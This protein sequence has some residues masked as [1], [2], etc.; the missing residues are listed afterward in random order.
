MQS[1]KLYSNKLQAVII[2]I[3]SLFSSLG[4]FASMNYN[5]NFE[6]NSKSQI[7]SNIPNFKNKILKIGQINDLNINE[8]F[9]ISQ[10]NQSL[11]I[12][13]NDKIGITYLEEENS[14]SIIEFNYYINE[15]QLI[16]NFPFEGKIISA[17]EINNGTFQRITYYNNLILNDNYKYIV[18]I[19]RAD[20]SGQRVFS[21]K[22]K[23]KLMLFE[24][25][26]NSIGNLTKTGLIGLEISSPKIEDIVNNLIKTGVFQNINHNYLETTDN[27]NLKDVIN[28]H[29]ITHVNMIIKELSNS[30]LNRDQLESLAK[31]AFEKIN[32]IDDEDIIYKLKIGITSE[33]KKQVQVRINKALDE[34]IKQR[35]EEKKMEEIVHKR[36]LK[37]Q[38]LERIRIAKEIEK[39]RLEKERENKAYLNRLKEFENARKQ[40]IIDFER[41]YK[42]KQNKFEKSIFERN[43]AYEKSKIIKPNNFYN[44]NNSGNIRTK[45]LPPEIKRDEEVTKPEPPPEE[46]KGNTASKTVKGE[47]DT[48]E[49]PI[50]PDAKGPEPYDPPKPSEDEIFTAVEQQAEFPGGPRAFE[51]FL[52]ENLRY[53][54]AAQRA[55]VGGK[56]YVQFVINTDG[57]IQDVQILK[58]IGL[59]CDEEAIRLIKVVPRWTP[60]K[61][62]GRL[63]RSRFTQPITFNLPETINLKENES[64]DKIVLPYNLS[65]HNA[66]EIE[67]KSQEIEV[68]K[69]EGPFK[70]SPFLNLP[71]IRK[72]LRI[73]E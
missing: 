53:P 55:N 19:R 43:W 60:G 65:N 29:T 40:A 36:E 12:F 62:A 37:E 69:E 9:F 63:V 49:P 6:L 23:N 64:G 4:G 71:N 5:L 22:S 14:I 27:L 70:I 31:N 45:F 16:M 54:S 38:E 10:E 35:E 13:L 51:A 41:A 39:R 44:F 7:Q 24:E 56:V 52:R 68:K 20:K 48:Y 73:I 28:K 17:N 3:I 58:S 47:T 34:Q 42:R 50:D 67:S 8:E 21:I 25:H 72:G 18:K 1:D 15:E 59:G 11:I 46:V 33:L 57:S 26:E 61:Q 32:F 30:N 2:F 66:K